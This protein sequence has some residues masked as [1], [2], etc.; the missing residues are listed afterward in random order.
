MYES[1]HITDLCKEKEVQGHYSSF[2]ES[3]NITL[4]KII[5]NISFGVFLPIFI[6]DRQWQPAYSPSNGHH[7]RNYRPD[8][9]HRLVARQ[10][11]KF[12]AIFEIFP[13][14]REVTCAGSGCEGLACS[15][16]SRYDGG[17]APPSTRP[18]EF[19]L[20]SPANHFPLI[21]LCP[22]QTRRTSKNKR[23]TDS[24]PAWQR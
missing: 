14:D 15:R 16:W 2:L 6:P 1:A 7:H 8:Q 4:V 18:A 9:S 3:G 12:D 5:Y 10:R 11:C 24:F 23:A 22:I 13:R 21:Q 17:K 19:Y 20:N